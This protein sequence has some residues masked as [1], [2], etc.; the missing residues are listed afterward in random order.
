MKLPECG[1]GALPLRRAGYVDRD[2]WIARENRRKRVQ[3]RVD[4]LAEG[5]L[6]KKE[7]S[8]PYIR[9]DGIR[10]TARQIRHAMGDDMQA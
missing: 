4:A 3:K 10:L 1:L 8:N 5:K 6:A 9:Q 2:G 7:Q